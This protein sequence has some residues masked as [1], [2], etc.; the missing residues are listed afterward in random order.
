MGLLLAGGFTE[1]TYG[2]IVG[3]PEGLLAGGE[4]QREDAPEACDCNREQQGPLQDK[5]EK[6][7]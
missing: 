3:D 6:I 2:S 5:D 1:E 7:K 4:R